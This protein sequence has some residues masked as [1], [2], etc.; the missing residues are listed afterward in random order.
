MMKAARSLYL[1]MSLSLLALIGFLD[2]LYLSLS[3]IQTSTSM[4]CPSGG[5]CE[6]VQASAWSTIPPGNGL[7]VAFLG[8]GG[9]L[10]F[11]ILGILSTQTNTL[12]PVPLPTL[13]LFIASAGVLFSLYLV[14]IQLVI[15]QEIC[16]W[17]MV[18]A[19]IELGIWIIAFFDWRAW[20]TTISHSSHAT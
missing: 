14:M 10:V 6:A 16:F 18:S 7:P 12:G 13:I 3:R 5:G 8:V 17:C 15:I 9:Y 4:V 20:R 11:L 1:R 2:S 19:G